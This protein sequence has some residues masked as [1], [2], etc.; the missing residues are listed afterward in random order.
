MAVWRSPPIRLVLALLTAAAA[1]YL[2]WV[3]STRLLEVFNGERDLTRGLSG[4]AFGVAAIAEAAYWLLP[5]RRRHPRRWHIVLAIAVAPL[6][7]LGVTS[8]FM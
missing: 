3:G 7:A 6:A 8:L 2:Y 4:A 1:A 5:L